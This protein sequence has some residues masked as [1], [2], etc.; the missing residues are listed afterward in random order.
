[1]LVVVKSQQCNTEETK[2]IMEN[3]RIQVANYSASDDSNGKRG[4]I[5]KQF[6]EEPFA[7]AAQ[8]KLLT[9]RTKAEASD[10]TTRQPIP[11][12]L[13]TLLLLDSWTRVTFFDNYGACSKSSHNPVLPTLPLLHL[14]MHRLL[15]QA[16]QMSMIP[17]TWR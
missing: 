15:F 12:I 7:R 6:S 17:L 14:Q 4:N 8:D 9:V 2:E 16:V 10:S 3:L 5:F 1:V 13:S 11:K